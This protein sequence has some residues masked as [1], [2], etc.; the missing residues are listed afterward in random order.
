MRQPKQ[1]PRSV[2]EWRDA[3]REGDLQMDNEQARQ[4][5]QDGTFPYEDFRE[6]IGREYGESMGEEHEASPSLMR[7]V[8]GLARWVYESSEDEVFPP[9]EEDRTFG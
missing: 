7:N 9:V 1:L 4:L 5:L 3:I 2:G 6:W 8:R